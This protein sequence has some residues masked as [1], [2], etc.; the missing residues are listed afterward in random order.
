MAMIGV[1]QCLIMVRV[2]VDA[3]YRSSG[4]T[5]L[6]RG[7]RRCNLCYNEH[8]LPTHDQAQGIF[9][10]KTIFVIDDDENLQTV[11]DIALTQDGYDVELASNGEEALRQ[12]DQ[13]Q[14]DLVLCDVMMPFVDGSQVWRVVREQLQYAG[15]P[16]VLMT[17][18]DRKP[19]FADLEVEGVVILHKPFS[20]EHLVALVRSSLD[21]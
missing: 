17:A 1:P 3:S 20:I 16:F 11:L 4:G 14:P 18:L 10:P 12:L 9:M 19:W 2:L 15:V 7:K 21:E 5:H 13:I 6:P 8:H